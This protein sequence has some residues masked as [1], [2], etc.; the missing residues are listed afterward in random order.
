MLLTLMKEV[1]SG[2]NDDETESGDNESAGSIV[3]KE[4]SWSIQTSLYYSDNLVP[5][6]HAVSTNSSKAGG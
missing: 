4:G 1:D 2:V 5:L 3:V 6:S